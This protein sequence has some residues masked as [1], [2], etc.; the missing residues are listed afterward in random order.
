MKRL[1]NVKNKL[2]LFVMTM[3]VSIYSFAQE[4]VTADVDISKSTTTTTWYAQPWIWIVGGAVFI[5]LL[6]ALIRG[7]SSKNA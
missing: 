7:N 1:E 4:K 6:V 3:L 2:V 5:L